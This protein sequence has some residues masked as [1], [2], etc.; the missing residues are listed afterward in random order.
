MAE[1]WLAKLKQAFG[2][3]D[4]RSTPWTPPNLAMDP[5]RRILAAILAQRQEVPQEPAIGAPGQGRMLGG[6]N[7]A[8]GAPGQGRM[9]GGPNAA[10]GAPGRGAMLGGPNARIGAPD[11]AMPMMAEPKMMPSH[12][13]G[14]ALARP[15]VAKTKAKAREKSKPMPQQILQGMGELGGFDPSALGGQLYEEMPTPPPTLDATSLPPEALAQLAQAPTSTIVP[16][17]EQKRNLILRALTLGMK[18]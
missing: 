16:P 13:T 11:A 12:V 9:L 18:G 7:A 10:I 2:P 3:N 4:V 15:A 6:P 8:I 14:A 5:I 17:A 1:N